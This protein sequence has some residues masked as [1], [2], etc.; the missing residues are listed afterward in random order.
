MAHDDDLTQAEAEMIGECLPKTLRREQ[1]GAQLS[2][3]VAVLAA[4]VGRSAAHE[5]DRSS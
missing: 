2:D 5:E 4:A 1:Q 3:V